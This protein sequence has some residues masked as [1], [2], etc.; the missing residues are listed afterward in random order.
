MN[1][2]KRVITVGILLLVAAVAGWL[3]VA[4]R[5]R[6]VEVVGSL[7]KKDVVELT[8]A[9]RRQM[10]HDTLPNFSWKS[11]SLLPGKLLRNATSHISGIY[12]DNN[13]AVVL[14]GSRKSKPPVMFQA[15]KLDKGWVCYGG[16]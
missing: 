8:A 15:Q 5:Q 13:T 1:K 16:F 2:K 4:S 7:S 6:P 10:W 3:I 9:V 11:L 14:L 12:G